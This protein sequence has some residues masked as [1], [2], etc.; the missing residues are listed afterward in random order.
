MT[1]QPMGGNPA[2][3]ASGDYP[4]A[5]GRDLEGRDRQ[6]ETES[7]EGA[8]GANLELLEVPTIG[9]GIEKGL[10]HINA[11]AVSLEGMQYGGFI[12][13]DGSKLAVDVVVAKGDMRR[14]V[15]LL[16]LRNFTACQQR[17]FP[18]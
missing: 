2:T 7:G 15:S 6:E 10:F 13:D 1:E 8:D 14:T 9:W 5:L 18:H 11:Q 16:F 4:D 3:L 12:A 17:V